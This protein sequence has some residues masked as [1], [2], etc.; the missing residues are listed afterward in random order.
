MP[1]INKR[2]KELVAE[3][4]DGNV[5]KFVDLVGISSHQVLNRIFSVDNRSG[6]YPK[7][8]AHILTAIQ[9]SLPQVDN[10]WLL[11]GVGE[12]LKA[13]NADLPTINYEKR[14]VPY[15]DVDFI[16]G[17]D[18]VLN[19]Q[20]INPLYYIDF[21]QYNA[22]DYWVNVSGH[23]MSPEVS[24]GDMVA[25]KELNDWPLHLLY[26]EMYALVTSENRTIKYVRKSNKGDDYLRLVPVNTEK[27]D[28]Q[29]IPASIVS[30]VFKVLGCAKKIQ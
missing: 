14:G 12:M 20:T 5:Q 2:I 10:G 21:K 15:F 1:D 4:S 30:K 26:G 13:D 29:D 19:D 28:E 6:K 16:G 17:F 22:A 18:I 7:P 27:Y 25:I 23:S 11:T 8:S 9:T 3:F 24:N